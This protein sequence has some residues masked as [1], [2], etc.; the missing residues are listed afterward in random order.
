M[1]YTKKICMFWYYV[2]AVLFLYALIAYINM[3]VKSVVAVLMVY[4]D[5][6]LIDVIPF[7]ARDFGRGMRNARRDEGYSL[8]DF[9]EMVGFNPLNLFLIEHGYKIPS[10]NLL[11]F[12][13]RAGMIVQYEDIYVVSKNS[14]LMK[15]CM[16]GCDR[17]I[18][19]GLGEVP[20]NVEIT[21]SATVPEVLIDSD[22]SFDEYIFKGNPML[23]IATYIVS[24]DVKEIPV[25]KS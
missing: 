3:K 25:N 1:L 21:Q 15:W 19:R 18:L 24:V 8:F 16:D 12:F 13:V 22:L 2:F 5:Y 7:Y 11:D 4:K 9:A 14:E 20:K 17:A 23:Y 6:K 10:L